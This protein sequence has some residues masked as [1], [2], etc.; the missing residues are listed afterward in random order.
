MIQR[1]LA[2]SLGCSLLASTALAD[3][4]AED[5]LAD[6]LNFLSGNGGIVARTTGTT[7]TSRGLTIDGYVL[8]FTADGADHEVEID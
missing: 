7:P 5:V 8:T 4:R 6:Q 3:L 1:I 2:A